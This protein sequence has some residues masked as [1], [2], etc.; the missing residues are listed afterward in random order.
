MNILILQTKAFPH[1][2]NS[3][4][5]FYSQLTDWLTENGYPSQLFYCYLDVEDTPYEN[6]LQ[7]PDKVPH[8]YSK[9][10]LNALS[11]YIEHRQIEVI[12]DY[13]HIITGLTRRFFLEI[14]KR[15]PK[16]K[17]FTM[18][19]NC[20]RHTSQLKRHLL[21]QPE[22][23][24]VH[25]LKQR[26]Q[27]MVPDL[28]LTLLELEVKRQNRLAYDTLDEVV[29]LSPA[30]LP[31]FRQLIGR[32][33]AQRLSAI[34]NAIRPVSSQIP[35]EKKKKEIVFAGRMEPEKA[36][37]KLLRIWKMVSEQL[38][39]WQLTLVGDGSWL[40]RYQEQARQLGLNRVVFTGFQ[41]A[42]PYIDRAS[43]I[44]LTS[45]IEGL[46]TVFTEAMSLG[47]VPVGFDSFRAIY[48]MIDDGQTG[49]IVP[50]GNYE[51]Y[52]QR[53]IQLCSDNELRIRM[54]YQAMNRENR[55]DIA[56]IGPLWLQAFRKHGL[57]PDTDHPKTHALKV[58]VYPR[59]P[60][61]GDH[62]TNPYVADF[63]QSLTDNGMEV[64][65]PPHKNPLFSLLSQTGRSDC[66]VFHWIENVPDY[67]HG[68]LQSA[69]TV[70]LL[71]ILRL[72][73]KKIIWFLH[74]Q[75]SHS[76]RHQWLKQQLTRFVCRI[77]D[78]IVTHASAGIKVAEHIYPG[79][80]NKTQFLHHP[81]KNRLDLCPKKN[82]TPAYDLLVWGNISPYKGVRELVE[83][84]A[85]CLKGRRIRIAG[86]CSDS[87]LLQQLQQSCPPWVEITNRT[88]TFEE[89]ASLIDDTRYVL[90]PYAS[91]SILSSG[92][93]M[94]SLSFGASVIG[95]DVGSFR[96]Y[97]REPLLC[98][99]TFRTLDDLPDLLKDTSRQPDPACYAR[100]LNSHD[101]QHF[102][103][104]F[105]QILNN[106]LRNQ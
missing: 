38:P 71:T 27:Q 106:L 69:A 19:H 22:R 51:M 67:K 43:V 57:I 16:L 37:D 9:A 94:D 73:G 36:V 56:H 98:V 48:D 31:E 35:P 5:W 24:D 78:R 99:Q 52:A 92:I 74:N 96:D 93:L 70:A 33:R 63:V 14:R 32:P 72:R 76:P 83:F 10:N 39:D 85:R 95:P 11:D 13:S 15:H 45:V 29:L 103:R 84:A 58:T 79:A 6:G 77:A 26:L 97:A 46:P 68:W 2:A 20:P 41:M 80:G 86:Y 49:F 28:Y 1:R 7:L 105:R 21:E 104:N 30:Y 54:A 47:T 82:S 4:S 55:Y 90:I 3:F 42:I 23:N 62:R 8:F 18:I 81:T 53:L 64:T 12:L 65:N 91:E 50:E 102:G 66:Y 34:P 61:T 87:R 60:V 75:T 101:W 59:L 89:L 44:C 17:V 40:S 100:F 25:T 88:Y